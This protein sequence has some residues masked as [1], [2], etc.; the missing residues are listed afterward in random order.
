MGGYDGVFRGTAMVR[1]EGDTRRDMIWWLFWLWT[2]TERRK[3]EF[4]EVLERD[5]KDLE[6]DSERPQ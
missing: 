6:V 3:R 1:V 4:A 5:A 2:K